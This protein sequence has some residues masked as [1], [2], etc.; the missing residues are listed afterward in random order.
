MHADWCVGLDQCNDVDVIG[1]S[2][3]NLSPF[4]IQVP[5]GAVIGN[6]VIDSL[7][8]VIKKTREISFSLDLLSQLPFLNGN[9]DIPRIILV[10]GHR[11]ENFGEGFDSI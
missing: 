7:F 3:F 4:S 10:T 1:S 11:R 2:I 9:V 6:T 5:S 8:S